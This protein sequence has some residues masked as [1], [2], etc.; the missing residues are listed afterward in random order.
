MGYAAVID[1]PQFDWVKV[2]MVVLV[3]VFSCA[4]VY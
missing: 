4:H 3:G 2:L 1:I